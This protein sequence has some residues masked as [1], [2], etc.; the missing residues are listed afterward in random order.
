MECN[1]PL[2]FMGSLLTC[3]ATAVSSLVM[4]MPHSPELDGIKS[5]RTPAKIY[6]LLKL[7]GDVV[8]L[9]LRLPV[10]N[11]IRFLPG[12]YIKLTN[13]EGSV[14]SYSLAAAP[15]LDKTLKMHI[16]RVEGGLFSEW[17]FERATV[18]DLLH[19]EGPFGNFFLREDCS[20][21]KTIFL[22]TGTGIAPIFS[23]LSSVT[24]EQ[25]NKLGG[26][27][28]YWGNRCQRDAYLTQ[29]LASLS[30]RMNFKIS[31]VYSRDENSK[32]HQNN[33]YVQDMMR[34]D[35]LTLQDAQVFACGNLAMIEAARERAIELGLRENLFHCDAFTAS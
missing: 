28:V 6:S 17:L 18:G 26:I 20:V 33:F 35:H 34:Q 27:W 31:E 12:Q 16:R 30:D 32:A 24:D 7:S 14:R 23:M 5:L 8:E 4:R 21:K 25:R 3:N 1:R 9:T 2:W 29:Q 10:A 15:S 19:A 22:A 13:R 11:E